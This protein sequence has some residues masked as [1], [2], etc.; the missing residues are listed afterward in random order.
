VRISI[1]AQPS[2]EMPTLENYTYEDARALLEAID[3]E[4]PFVIERVDFEDANLPREM[5]VEQEPLAG[6]ILFGGERIVLQ[7]SVGPEITDITVPNFINRPESEAVALAT[8]AGLIVGTPIRE[9][10]QHFA[11]GMVSAQS[12][13]ALETAERNSV[14]VFTISTGP[15]A[16]ATPQATPAPA[17]TQAP[18]PAPTTAAPTQAPDVAATAPPPATTE[19][20]ADVPARTGTLNIQLPPLIE[21]REEPHH[22]VIWIQIDNAE[23]VIIINDPNVLSWHLPRALTAEAIN[24]LANMPRALRGDGSEMFLIQFLADGEAIWMAEHI[25]RFDD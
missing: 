16:M 5:V 17:T 13:Q 2:F 11:A 8:E 15:S 14:I 25:F 4:I 7:V 20:P 6:Y 3:L 12:I 10:N 24:G 1:G 19:P 21:A 23:P 9:E 18:T 22:L